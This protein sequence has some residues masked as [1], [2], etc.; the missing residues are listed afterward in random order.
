MGKHDTEDADYQ[1]ASNDSAGLLTRSQRGVN[2]FLKRGSNLRS[3]VLVGLRKRVC[4]C[5]WIYS[6]VCLSHWVL[7]SQLGPGRRFPAS[8]SC[9]E[10]PFQLL[11][12]TVRIIIH[13]SL[14]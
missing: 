6:S 1:L 14:G 13:Y 8:R 4:V 5:V 3:R 12:S 7:L 10:P 2:E 9:F 11:V